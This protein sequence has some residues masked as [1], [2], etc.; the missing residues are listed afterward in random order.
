MLTP[1]KVL[2]LGSRKDADLARD[3]WREAYDYVVCEPR[4]A[5]NG[6]GVD[7]HFEF[8]L[9]SG[10]PAQRELETAVSA[11]SPL[12]VLLKAD[13]PSALERVRA[14][15]FVVI[16]GP[17]VGLQLVQ[18]A[19]Y[20][21][22]WTAKQSFIS[23]V[24]GPLIHDLRGIV[25]IVHLSARLREY[26]G[27]DSEESRNQRRALDA[28]RRIGWWLSDLEAHLALRL[29]PDRAWPRVPGSNWNDVIGR[30]VSDLAVDHPRRA[31]ALTLGSRP[32]CTLSPE[33]VL[34]VLRGIFE[35]ALKTTASQE[36]IHFRLEG[37]APE[38]L[39]LSVCAAHSTPS[40][41]LEAALLGPG[42]WPS[43]PAEDV[44][45]HLVSACLLARATG[46]EVR[47][48]WIGQ[49]LQAEARWPSSAF[50]P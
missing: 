34:L 44:P 14:G 43:G 20:C 32:R 24:E 50:Y 37:E 45:F 27:Q 42:H 38:A 15:V 5:A 26:A 11:H 48:D 49:R 30:R 8:V 2:L 47:V 7:E 4:D 39:V 16:R 22:E 21:A 35:V 6:I 18:A 41:A 23:A 19:R 46:G 25:G 28:C 12:I 33:H 36:A 10:L 3:T 31:L 29:D 1:G 17:A 13:D 40:A 9:S